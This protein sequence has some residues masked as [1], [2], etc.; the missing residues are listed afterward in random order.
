M[1]ASIFF[2]KCHICSVNK[3]VQMSLLDIFKDV[4]NALETDKSLLFRLLDEHP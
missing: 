1:I 2:S 3:Y 4:E